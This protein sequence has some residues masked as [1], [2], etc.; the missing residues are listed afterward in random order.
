MGINTHANVTADGCRPDQNEIL[1][2]P[3]S[4]L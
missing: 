2:F 1:D 4:I 3:F